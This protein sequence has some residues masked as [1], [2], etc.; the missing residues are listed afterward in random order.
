M[1]VIRTRLAE[2]AGKA[3]GVA[4]IIDVFRAFTC[5]P[6]FFHFGALSVRLEPNT[7]TA[8]A[9]KKEHPDWIL[10]GEEN[11]VPLEGADLSNSPE[12][13]L[14]KGK[15][16]FRGRTVIHR[17]TAGVQ[18]AAAAMQVAE[19]VLLGGFLTARATAGYILERRP[20]RVTL[21]A[22]GSRGT[23]PAAEDEA[24]SL[25]HI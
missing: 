7:A 25:I 9:L 1:K 21:V 17:T 11:E 13:I 6:F 4:V 3:R 15:G 12:A 18:G 20:D 5:A 14:R 10:A 2:G 19:E 23:E 16:F 22:M 24:L 8:M